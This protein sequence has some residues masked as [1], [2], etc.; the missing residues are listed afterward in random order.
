MAGLALFCGYTRWECR[1]EKR[2]VASYYQ[3]TAAHLQLHEMSSWRFVK[4]TKKEEEE[5]SHALIYTFVFEGC[6]ALVG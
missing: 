3:A 6:K 4:T 1:G 2:H 5:N